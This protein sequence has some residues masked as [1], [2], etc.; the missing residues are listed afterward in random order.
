MSTQPDLTDSLVVGFSRAMPEVLRELGAALMIID[1][2]GNIVDANTSAGMLCDR[3]LGELRAMNLQ[4]VVW[5]QDFDAYREWV[6]RLQTGAMGDPID[7]RLL[8]PSGTRTW[9]RMHASPMS[10][11]AGARRFIV[12][13]EDIARQT[14]TEESLR[15][16]TGLN[17]LLTEI[18][19]DY[20]QVTGKEFDTWVT[21]AL[22]KIAQFV[23][24]DRSY[25]FSV[26]S[27]GRCIS[28]SHEWCAEGIEPQIDLLQEIP[29]EAFPY[30]LPFLASGEALN[31][32]TLA[33]L[34][35]EA[36]FER[37]V[38]EAQGIKSMLALPL[39]AGGRLVGF[40][41][42]DAVFHQRVWPEEAIL[43]LRSA[44]SLFTSA[45]VHLLTDTLRE[46][47]ERY[48]T[49]VEG[50]RSIIFRIDRDGAWSLLNKA[51][52]EFSD[53]PVEEALGQQ[54]V[55]FLHPD[56]RKRAKKALARMASTPDE[57]IRRM[58]L[59]VVVRGE[60]RWIEVLARVLWDAEGG[61]VGY[62]GSIDDI[63]D[64]KRAEETAERALE[65]AR[66]ASQAKSEFLSRM[67]HELRTPLNAIIG[68]SQ[69]LAMSGLDSEDAESVGHISRAGEHLLE[70]INEVL[71]IV[72]IEAGRM[73][74]SVEP[75]E[76]SEIIDES[77][78][79]VRPAAD[80][81]RL[82]VRTS[83]G[84]RHALWVNADRQR[85]R[86][87]LVNLLGNAVKY[88]CEAGTITVNCSPV[89]RGMVRIE[90]EDTGIGIAPGRLSDVFAPFERLGA[91][92]TEVEG[93][94]MGMTVT[95]RLVEAMG[96]TIT[97]K[98][99]QG[100]G[101]CFTVELPAAGDRAAQAPAE[102]PATPQRHSEPGEHAVVLYIEDN[103][104]N[105]TLVRRILAYRPHI[106]LT[107][108]YEG[109]TGVELAR[110]TRPD[111]VLLDLHLPDIN[112]GEVLER[113]AADP[114]TRDTPV[115]IVSAD[116]S[117][118]QAEKLVQR[119]A[120][121]YVTKPIDVTRFLQTIDATLEASRAGGR[122]SSI[123][124]VAKPPTHAFRT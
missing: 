68:F 121:D 122:P 76:L 109:L 26:S 73:A 65:E 58:E 34:P 57:D 119:G 101:S 44:N 13:V 95:K 35:E 90:V 14:A 102:L 72:S 112:G 52:E 39:I 25:I 61:V 67:S 96:G 60:L 89:D 22:G 8:H 79:L 82:H 48:R 31:L 115:I 43:L 120:T 59:R 97:V 63:T 103:P 53:Q 108:A 33:D 88:N 27:D 77:L 45:L 18:S 86:Q 75:V 100:L 19:C 41:G 114:M 98:S 15:Y 6:G 50:V 56:D 38:L 106:E 105:V 32:S 113:L 17:T 123:S 99:T 1:E 9:A 71:D 118:G 4:G 83:L 69:L 117:A 11:H 2:T 20:D 116:A 46:S 66:R 110:T 87:V 80:Q 30:M 111:L 24:A 29:I 81:R 124:G 21:E 12:H 5:G 74:L 47:E 92:R 23:G 85:L 10:D 3:D 42:F 16:R 91:E 40:T 104:S 37:Q 84:V 62:A 94:G 51:W 107:V 70:L 54:A 93:T 28:N 49:V 64:R 7:L 55:D 36:A 78:S